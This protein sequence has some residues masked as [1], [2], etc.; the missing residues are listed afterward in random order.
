MN[1]VFP[2]DAVPRIEM[3]LKGVEFIIPF[4]VSY[5]FYRPSAFPLRG[6]PNYVHRSSWWIVCDIDYETASEIGCAWIQAKGGYYLSYYNGR[7]GT[8]LYI[9]VKAKEMKDILSTVE[10]MM[11]RAVSTSGGQMF[12]QDIQ[13]FRPAEWNQE[14]YRVYSI[15]HIRPFSRGM[16]CIPIVSEGAPNAVKALKKKAVFEVYSYLT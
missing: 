5:N 9:E 4:N 16:K 8:R 13:H 11:L 2:S 1:I 7:T 6:L 14:P 12:K 15:V 3:K 10:N